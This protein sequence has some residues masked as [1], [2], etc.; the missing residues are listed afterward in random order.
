MPLGAAGADVVGN[1]FS[2]CH[3]YK[4]AYAAVLVTCYCFQCSHL[5][6]IK[7]GA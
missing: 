2:Y 3:T 5:F 7:S 6:I 1:V 4:G